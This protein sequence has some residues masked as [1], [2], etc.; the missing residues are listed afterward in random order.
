MSAAAVR[1]SPRL[2]QRAQQQQQQ[3]E[4]QEFQFPSSD[5]HAPAGPSPQEPH[6]HAADL[7]GGANSSSPAR[8]AMNISSL[9]VRAVH[10]QQSLES[11]QLTV[12]VMLLL[13]TVAVGCGYWNHAGE[14]ARELF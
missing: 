10:R 1:H 4:N 6:Q 9:A 5:S 3:Q 14:R 7:S 8:P 2:Q 12:T 11:A 13:W